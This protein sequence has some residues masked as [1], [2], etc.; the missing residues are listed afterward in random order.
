MWLLGALVATQT[1][2]G[3]D[4]SWAMVVAQLMTAYL[5]FS[6][7]FQQRSP[8]I[9]LI[10]AAFLFTVIFYN[11]PIFWLG[12]KIVHPTSLLQSTRAHAW[13][14]VFAH[15]GFPL[16]FLAYALF[17]RT[18][19]HIKL[20]VHR[21]IALAAGIFVAVFALIIV[22]GLFAIAFE[23]PLS[24][25]FGLDGSKPYVAI[26]VS[27]TVFA[28]GLVSLGAFVAATRLHTLTQLWLALALL[29][30]L[31]DVGALGLVHGARFTVGWTLA[32]VFGLI[33]CV[34]IPLLYVFEFHWIYERLHVFGEAVRHQAL[35]DEMTGVGNKRQ[36]YLAVDLEWRRAMRTGQPVSVILVDVDHLRDYE[37]SSGIIEV[38]DVLRKVAIALQKLLRRA[39]D[40]VAR[41]EDGEFALVLADVDAGKAIDFAR[42]LASEIERLQ[43]PHPAIA[44]PGIVSVTTAATTT[45]PAMGRPVSEFVDAARA[46]LDSAQ[47]NPSPLS[48]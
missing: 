35:V 16:F 40:V 5:L 13:L 22:L 25:L 21:A 42:T 14:G 32:Q 28:I 3:F 34:A 18:L 44:G 20:S 46:A 19:E 10:A 15:A 26:S 8:A 48:V 12:A 17:D 30:A 38:E 47:K 31:L 29:A 9:A 11:V 43:I 23:A 45:V 36:F 6:Q 1:W 24:A 41:I 37:E 39:G 2:L 4:L 27:L 7:L 33:A